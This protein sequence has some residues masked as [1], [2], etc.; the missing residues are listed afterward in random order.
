[1]RLETTVGGVDFD[2][3]RGSQLDDGEARAWRLFGELVVLHLELPFG[4]TG[5]HPDKR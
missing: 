2:S 5:T 4:E 1:M 3:K